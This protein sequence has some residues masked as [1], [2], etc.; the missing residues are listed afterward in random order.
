M[1]RFRLSIS[2]CLL[3]TSPFSVESNKNQVKKYIHF[4]KEE[5]LCKHMETGFGIILTDGALST[6]CGKQPS[7]SDIFLFSGCTNHVTDYFPL[8]AAGIQQKYSLKLLDPTK[9]GDNK[10]NEKIIV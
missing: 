6:Y 8:M 5:V 1:L 7:T 9:I 10:M 4:L 3:S 2:D